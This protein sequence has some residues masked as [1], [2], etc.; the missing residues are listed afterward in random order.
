[1]K[2]K[3]TIS[4]SAEESVYD[5]FIAIS[6]N[7]KGMDENTLSLIFTPGFSTKRKNGGYGLADIDKLFKK[8]GEMEVF[9]RPGEGTI[10]KIHMYMKK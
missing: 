6:D 8:W 2:A 4:I 7:G 9:S 1:M 5:L 10:I 3:P